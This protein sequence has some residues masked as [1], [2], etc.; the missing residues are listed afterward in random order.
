MAARYARCVHYTAIWV[1]TGALNVPNT[2]HWQHLSFF[3][4]FFSQ[5]LPQFATG[6][7]R[8]SVQLDRKKTLLPHF[9]F[10]FVGPSSS[11]PRKEKEKKI[12]PDQPN[13]RPD[14][15]K[16][17]TILE[18][19][20]VFQS[21]GPANHPGRSAS[22]S[23]VGPTG[24]VPTLCFFLCSLHAVLGS[25]CDYGTRATGTRENEGESP[26]AHPTHRPHPLRE[27]ARS[28]RREGEAGPARRIVA[29]G[30]GS[31]GWAGG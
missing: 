6:S 30:D 23:A 1:T 8:A 25:S 15:S 21:A 17:T 13:T 31:G 24:P 7:A 16:S 5:Q 9:I 2:W 3:S 14:Q 12:L 18:T 11:L 20:S 19:S 28:R 10:F 26:P 29:D 27:R 4:F 22:C